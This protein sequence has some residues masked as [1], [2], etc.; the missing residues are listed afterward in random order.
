[1]TL[2]VEYSDASADVREVYD[3]I[4]AQLGFAAVPNFFKAQAPTPWVLFA[5]WDAVKRL[6]VGGR[7]DRVLKELILIE[8]SRRNHCHYCEAAHFALCEK[9]DYKSRLDERRTLPSRSLAMIEVAL[10]SIAPE[11]GAGVT[12]RCAEHNIS[13]D[14]RRE[15]VGMAALSHYL[16]GIATGLRVPLDEQLRETADRVLTETAMRDILS[17]IATICSAFDR[18]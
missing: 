17:R 2:L 11:D 5:S 12:A 7:V 13:E 1:M 16:N 6:L 15:L 10:L 18:R 8:V 14:E 4:I 3:E 9:L